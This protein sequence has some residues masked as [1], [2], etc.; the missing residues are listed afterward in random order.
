MGNQMGVER[1]QLC[2]CGSFWIQGTQEGWVKKNG[3]G[4]YTLGHANRDEQMS[5]KVGVEQC[6][7]KPIHF[8]GRYMEGLR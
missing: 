8:S 7:I 1:R 2:F 4:K 5:N 6:A 3:N